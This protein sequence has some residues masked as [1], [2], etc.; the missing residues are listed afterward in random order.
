M[1]FLLSILFNGNFWILLLLIL[2]GIRVTLTYLQKLEYCYRII[3]LMSYHISINKKI[4]TRIQLK[5]MSPHPSCYKPAAIGLKRISGAMNL[6]LP[7]LTSS[8][9]GSLKVLFYFKFTF[10]GWLSPR[11]VCYPS[12]CHLKR[13]RIFI[14]VILLFRSLRCC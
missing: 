11:T 5:T 2:L 7:N 6:S 8:P 3:S 1:L 10:S 4:N 12:L 14:L 9:S 13:N